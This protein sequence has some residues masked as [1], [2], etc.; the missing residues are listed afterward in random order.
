MSGL[1]GSPAHG[2]SAN[3]AST[4]PLG[5]T[6]PS[7][8]LTTRVQPHLMFVHDRTNFVMGACDI[9]ETIRRRFVSSRIW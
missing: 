9:V 8:I 4:V 1:N 3:K 7:D 2:H 6:A 5:L